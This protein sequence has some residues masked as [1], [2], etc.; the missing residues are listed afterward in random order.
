LRSKKNCTSSQTSA[1]IDS[2]IKNLN[3]LSYLRSKKKLH[4][5][6][7]QCHHWFPPKKPKFTLII[8]LK[9]KLHLIPDQCYP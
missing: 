5:F 8:A 6:P 3:S 1:I 4:F 9:E 7:N 2:P